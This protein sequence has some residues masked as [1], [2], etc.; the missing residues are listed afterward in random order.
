MYERTLESDRLHTL[1]S[2]RILDT[3]P[4]SAFDRITALA[5]KVFDAPIA[6]VS[7][8]DQE[9]LWFKSR[10]GLDAEGVSN[11][12]WTVCGATLAL[13]PGSV[14]VVED[15]AQDDRFKSSPLV[16]GPPNIRF[17][18]GAVL[19]APDGANLGSL[20]VIDRQPRPRPNDRDLRHLAALAKIVV[21][22][23]EFHRLKWM[24]DERRR[25]LSL[26]ERMTGLG[27]WRYDLASGE[28]SWSDETYRIH[29]LP[30]D[31][32]PPSYL[33]VLA[34]YHEDDRAEL[35]RLVERA[36]TTGEGYELAARV[37]QPNGRVRNVL[38]K[39]ECVRNGADEIEAICG[40]FSDVTDRLAQEEFT[41]KIAD[42]V[43]ALI[44]YWDTDLR[45]RFANSR[46][47]EGLGL[48][49]EQ[50][51]G[52]SFEDL[53][54]SDAF[55]RTCDPM[56]ACLEGSPQSFECSRTGPRGEISQY[57]IQCLPDLDSGGQVRGA[58]TLVTDITELKNAQES[59]RLAKE[60]A[61][62]ASQAKSVFLTTMSH[63]IRTPLNGVL[64]MAQAM[65]ADDLSL[66]QRR[67]LDVVRQSGET[68][69][70]ILNDLLDMAKIE[71]SKIEVE[72]VEFDLTKLVGSAQATF[73]TLIAEKGLAFNVDIE[74][75][76]KGLYRGDPTRLRQILYNLISNAG[77]FTERGEVR[78]TVRRDPVHLAITVA[79]TGIGIDA[80][81]QK[82]LFEQ[83]TQA[84]A[85]TTRRF[86]GSGLGLSI[87]RQLAVMMGGSLEVESK[88]GHGA[89]F[90]LRL[91]LP[92]LGDLEP[93]L[94]PAPPV[95]VRQ[96]HRRIRILAAED[97]A[98]NQVVLKSLLG[99]IGM[100]SM[101]VADGAAAVA[102][103]SDRTWDIILMDIC[104]PVMDGLNAARTIRSME[105]AAQRLKTP[106]L[107]LTAN[108]MAHQVAE[109]RAAGMDGHI[110]KPIGLAELYETIMTLIEPA[111]AAA[112][113][114]R[115]IAV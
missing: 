81:Q 13:G 45:C 10:F 74:P 80:E 35:A 53:L 22:E 100:D 78:I 88:A 17:Y 67:R 43:P 40:V 96:H 107:A 113:D 41:R 38:A 111:Q 87:S 21:D 106:I 25:L 27:Q 2:Y 30:S 24:A 46:F 75:S 90:T 83:F 101:M 70:N 7:L 16:I 109:Y 115:V 86:G 52:A 59:L 5:A 3:P 20:C 44:G 50:I 4:D 12:S 15:A 69:L 34:L 114:Q 105:A 93:P 65:A 91:P 55:A 9:R 1:K 60:E 73:M 32:P 82:R 63:E 58:Y 68:L 66:E 77:K 72:T 62:A 19:T 48:Q 64:G 104:M 14:L 97:N 36:A 57:W 112:P 18:A 51:I 102:A 31:G 28:V 8:I 29:G 49:R 39:A 56:L 71:A 47:L 85:S 89:R 99:Q 94:L 61:E 95:R 84:D 98:V 103:W 108:A 23:M 42:N 37:R 76:A 33:G 11:R 26:A 54:G 110:S 6:L 79:D 92:Y